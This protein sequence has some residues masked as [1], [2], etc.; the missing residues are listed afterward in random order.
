MT[1]API[2]LTR[3]SSRFLTEDHPQP[4]HDIERPDLFSF[5]PS[6]DETILAAIHPEWRRNL[7]A[8]LEQ[9]TSSQAA[10]MVHVLHIAL[11]VISAVVTVLETV[12]AFHQVKTSVWFGLETSLV[13]LFTM[14]YVARC[15]A[16]SGT[17][18]GLFRWMFSFF[19]II[20]FLSVAPYYLEL[21][22][23]QDTSVFF[24]FSILRMFRL[25]RVF[26]P[27]RSNNTVLLTIE[28]MYIS[29]RQSQHA[30]FALGFFVVMVLTVFST[31]LYFAERG[32]WDDILETFIN[33]D[34]D[35]SQFASIPA[36]ACFVLGREFSLVWERM[37]RDSPHS[38]P[39]SPIT[40]TFIPR[41]DPFTPPS[42]DL[43]NR[44][45]AHNQTELS[46]QITEL[47]SIVEAQGH[48]IARLAAAIEGKG[49]GRQRDVE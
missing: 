14:E 40:S 38:E 13:A 25:L 34:G 16:W 6:R 9:P 45:L 30:L 17:W 15:F 4:Q 43:S 2:E 32:T 19:G 28:V 42:G 47:R 7:F 3:V 18:M 37:T 23:A 39:S 22:L 31:L 41:R 1:S 5:G 26:R 48:L 36:A 20:D 10:F 27:F 29:V 44:K 12:P 8:L 49:K 33:T 24:R 46:N 35:P 21:I 11:I